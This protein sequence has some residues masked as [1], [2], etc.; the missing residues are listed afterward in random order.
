MNAIFDALKPTPASYLKAEREI[1]TGKEGSLRH[2]RV[3]VLGTFTTNYLKP[4]LTVEGARRGL[5]IDAY[6]GPFNQMEQETLDESS[7]LYQFDPDVVIVASRLEEMT[8]DLVNRFLKLSAEE[9]DA[10]GERSLERL[11]ALL[12]AVRQKTAA[13]VLLFNFAPPSLLNAG[14]ADAGMVDSQ[15]AVISRLNG[16]LA[17]VAGSLSGVFVFDLARVITEVGIRR[18]FDAKLWHMARLPFSV[19]A[20][21]AIGERLART[22]RA[23]VLPPC[24]C[25]AV[26]LDNTLWG[27]VVGEDGLGGIALGDECP[28]NAYKDFQRELLSLRDRGVLL[29]I[30]SKNN[31]DDALAVFDKHP[32][33]LLKREHFAATQIHWGD[34]AESL[35]AI[36][37]ELNLGLDSVAFLDDS[38]AEREWVRMKM[39][40]VLVLDFP[41]GPPTFRTIEESGAFDQL[42]ISGEDR[43]RTIFY[44]RESERSKLQTQSV[45]LEEFLG[46]LDITVSIGQVDNDTLPRVAQLVGKTNQFNLTTRRHTEGAIS[47]MLSR[48]CIALWMRV[49]DRFGDYGLVGVAL[50]MP[51]TAKRWEIDTFLLS[52]R[53]I[54]RR[55]EDA[56]LAVLIRQISARGGE[57]VEGVYIPTAK[58][59]QVKAF[60][61]A[62]GFRVC[63]TETDRWEWDLSQGSYLAP[64]LLKVRFDD[65][66]DD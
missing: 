59:A 21:I 37:Q 42:V 54:G 60:F 4:Y 61:P 6:F 43:E 9:I 31:E 32:D 16:S 40:E 33:C 29:A 17:R 12:Q 56:L 5:S 47:D 57:V 35:L 8:P 24:K 34:K 2:V 39:P 65:E 19:D 10:L 23:A 18:A 51:L 50:A 44:Q 45:S 63:G 53:M 52:C 28:G 36:A 27:G 13:T 25:L 64:D 1:S 30:A 55:A 66:S 58:N 48:G 3:A 11:R 62:R 49:K 20:Q 14:L 38:P 46:D 22:I 7:A 15:T 26:D 41:A